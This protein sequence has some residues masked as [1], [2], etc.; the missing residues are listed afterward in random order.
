MRTTA[1]AIAVAMA[2]IVGTGPVS[3]L[4]AASQVATPKPKTDEHEPDER[5]SEPA[6]VCGHAGATDT[7]QPGEELLAALPGDV[8]EDDGK[9]VTGTIQP[10][11]RA[12]QRRLRATAIVASAASGTRITTALAASDATHLQDRLVR[13]RAWRVGARLRTAGRPRWWRR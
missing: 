8:G 2:T 1:A 10:A 9:T 5:Q 11:K 4:C 6:M 7:L 12:R 3:R 13:R